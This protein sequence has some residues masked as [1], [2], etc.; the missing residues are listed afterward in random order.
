MNRPIGMAILGVILAGGAAKADFVIP[1]NTEFSGGTP[2][3]GSLSPWM[4]ATFSQLNANTVHLRV[5]NTH[6]VGAE[7]VSGFYF[8]VLAS[9]VSNPTLVSFSNFTGSGTFSMPGVD[10]KSANPLQ[11]ASFKADGD[12]Y[13][14]FRLDFETSDLGGRF[15][16]GDALEFDMTLSTGL[17]FSWF[18]TGSEPGGGHGSWDAA[19]HVQG[20]G[21]NAQYSGWI[22]GNHGD[23]V[24]TQVIPLPHGA[25]MATAGLAWLLGTGYIRRRR[26]SK[27]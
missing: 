27:A 17:L 16:A 23:V 20:I 13:F 18:A 21:S 4:T 11:D 10:R 7:F 15:G 25:G 14:D 3:A 9:E 1:L 6:L 19:A 5:E 12:G 24:T 26:E 8:N 2:P 22:G